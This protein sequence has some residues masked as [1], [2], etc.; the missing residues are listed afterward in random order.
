MTNNYTDPRDSSWKP[1]ES[2]TELITRL[3]E[4]D[5]RLT[6][7]VLSQEILIGG[8][9]SKNL[10]ATGSYNGVSIDCASYNS[11][12]LQLSF[13]KTGVLAAPDEVSFN[14]Q[15]KTDASGEWCTWMDNS[16]NEITIS[17]A[18]APCHRAY[19]GTCYGENMRVQMKSDYS[20]SCAP[21]TIF[22]RVSGNITLTGMG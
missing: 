21:A 9:S 2:F 13:Y 22:F 16:F 20:G 10:D 12:L 1:E 7:K 3:H 14:L 18:D 4:L 15:V 5:E 6:R 17:A 11:F 8:E 19:A